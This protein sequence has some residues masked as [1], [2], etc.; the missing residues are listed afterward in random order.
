LAG[1][2]DQ[3]DHDTLD[4]PTHGE[5]QLPFFRG[6]YGQYPYLPRVLPY[7]ENDQVMMVSLLFGTASCSKSSPTLRRF[8]REASLPFRRAIEPPLF[9]LPVQGVGRPANP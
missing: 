9:R 2:E 8:L 4:D 1:C 5:G 7:A 3:H 6:C